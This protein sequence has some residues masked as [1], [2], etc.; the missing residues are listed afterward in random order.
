MKQ[1]RPL[2]QV[3]L[4]NTDRPWRPVK[5]GWATVHGSWAFVVDLQNTQ[6]IPKRRLIGS[7]V[8]FTEDA[9]SKRRLGLIDR[10]LA[11]MTMDQLSRFAG[12]H[13][14]EKFE[15]MLQGKHYYWRKPGCLQRR[16]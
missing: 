3:W 5:T 9:A 4:I 14:P 10:M 7:T 13:E 2:V 11:T 6:G 15:V 8:F 16:P 12:I 1:Q